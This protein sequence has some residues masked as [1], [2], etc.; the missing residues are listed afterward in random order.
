MV[1]GVAQPA[2]VHERL[3]EPPAPRDPAAVTPGATGETAGAPNP[4]G[5]KGI[6]RRFSV[7]GSVTDGPDLTGVELVPASQAIDFTFDEAIRDVHLVLARSA[8]ALPTDVFARELATGDLVRASVGDDERELPGNSSG[9]QISRDGRYVAFVY[10]AGIFLRDLLRIDVRPPEIDFGELGPSSSRSGPKSVEVINRGFGPL[11]IRR[12]VLAGQDG[13]EF[14]VSSDRCTHRTLH[15]TQ[16]CTLSV[17]FVPTAAGV[18]VGDL[19]VIDTALGAP[20][21]VSLR[22]RGPMVEPMAEPRPP[23]ATPGT[24]PAVAVSPPLGPPGSV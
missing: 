23:L 20:H 21:V 14:E 22:G 4:L 10:T 17:A 5:V 6:T 8:P 2:A 15:P 18:R 11:V 3:A 13:G 1:L 12:I 16:R 19:G 9:P 7:A 24:P